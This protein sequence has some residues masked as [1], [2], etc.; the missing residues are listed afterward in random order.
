MRFCSVCGLSGRSWPCAGLRRVRWNAPNAL[1]MRWNAPFAPNCA[2]CA[3]LRRLRRLHRIAPFARCLR[4]IAPIALELRWNSAYSLAQSE[5]YPVAVAAWCSLLA[6]VREINN[7]G[8]TLNDCYCL[9]F[10]CFFWRKTTNLASID[11]L[12]CAHPEFCAHFGTVLGLLNIIHISH[13]RIDLMGAILFCSE[14][15]QLA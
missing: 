2:K 8:Q 5:C 13:M 6:A 7:A 14:S 9:P 11:V 15:W 3:E 1:E 10:S 4:R 12:L